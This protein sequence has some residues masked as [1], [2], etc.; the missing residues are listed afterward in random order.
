MDIAGTSPPIP[1]PGLW[2]LLAIGLGSVVWQAA[3]GITRR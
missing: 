1:E 2:A 3:A